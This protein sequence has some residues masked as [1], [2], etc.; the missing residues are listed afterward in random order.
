MCLVFDIEEH[1]KREQPCCTR[2][3]VRYPD[4]Q[5]ECIDQ[6]AARMRCPMYNQ[7]DSR[8]EATVAVR[9]MMGGSVSSK[10]NAP[11]YAHF[12]KAWHKATTV[13]QDN[14]HELC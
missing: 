6:E 12:H 3:N 4:G 10:N 9:E 1:V 5:D 2:T 8:K 7:H 13:G 14:L 11:F